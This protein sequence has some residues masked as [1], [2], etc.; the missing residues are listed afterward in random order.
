MKVTIHRGTREIGGSC[1]EVSTE[2]TRIVLDI[3]MPLVKPG[4]DPFDMREYGSFDGP[5]LVAQKVLPDLKGFYQWDTLPKPDALFLSHAHLDHYGFINFVKH[6]IPCYMGEGTRKL[7]EI[8]N[9]FTG[10]VPLTVPYVPFKSGTPAKVG[11]LTVTPYLM[12]HSAFDAYAFLVEGGGKRVLYSGD[13]REHGRKQKAFQWF[14][15]NVPK[16]MDMLLLEG[17]MFG[18]T[19][20]PP[21]TEKQIEDEVFDLL[22]RTNGLVILISSGQ[23]IDRLVS[24]YRACLRAQRLL[25]VDVYI[26]NVLTALKDLARLPYPS[27]QFAHMRVFFPY[28]LCKRLALDGKRELLTTFRNYRISKTEITQRKREIAMMARPSMVSD[29]ARLGDLSDSTAVYSM[30]EGYMT[31]PSTQRLLDFLKDRGTKVLSVH[32]SGHAFIATLRKVVNTLRPK[33]LV[34]IHTFHPEAY[35]KLSSSVLQL[36]DGVGVE[37]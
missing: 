17:S 26:A 14:L 3:G 19:S 5:S 25:V 24:F 4:G 7:V 8:T 2:A 1:V 20:E 10:K 13:F 15:A 21:K 6:S 34:P 37:V 32:T 16:E 27:P 35:E 9:L 29:L 31:E 33:T 36:S 11:G 12:D 18:R 30:W 28:H 23:N 22:R